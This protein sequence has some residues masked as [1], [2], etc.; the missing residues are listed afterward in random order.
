M[1]RYVPRLEQFLRTLERVEMRT[2]SEESPSNP[3]LSAQMRDFWAT[4]RFWFDYEIRKSFDIDVVYWTALHN[5]GDD[6]LDDEMREEAEK[7][8]DLKMDQLK[9]YKAECD[10]RFPL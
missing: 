10:V 2:S 1:T 5:D 4:G 9:A 3:L 7:L 8:V 6:V